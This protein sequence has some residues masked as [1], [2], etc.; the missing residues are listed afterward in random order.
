MK[1]FTIFYFK[2][3]S[4]GWV[5]TEFRSIIFFLSFSAYLIPFW[6]KIMP[7]IGFFI[8]LFFFSYFFLNFLARIEYERNSGLKFVSLFLCLSHPILAKNNA[9]KCFFNFLNFL[10]IFFRISFHGSSMN[11]IQV[12]NF[13][14][15]FLGQSHP[16][17]AKNNDGKGF[18]N[19]LNF[20]AILFFGIFLPGTSVNGIRD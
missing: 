9:E 8:F 1:F 2:F 7:E 14:F 6:Q 16:I 12:W 17:L 3:S 10:A 20:F 15:L 18:F 13:F 11:G 5:G 19:F 4:S